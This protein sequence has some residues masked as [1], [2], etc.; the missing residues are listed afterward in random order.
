MQIVPEWLLLPRERGA[1]LHFQ[2][3]HVDPS[4]PPPR[5]RAVDGGLRGR[6]NE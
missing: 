5:V 3:W 1:I 4:H 6:G 2:K